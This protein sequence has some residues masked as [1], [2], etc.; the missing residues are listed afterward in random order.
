MKFISTRGLE[1]KR[2]SAAE[3]IKNGMATDGGL[4]MPEEIPSFQQGELES[5]LGCDYFERAAKVIGV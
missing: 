4:Y 1:N 5:L 2:V 3:A